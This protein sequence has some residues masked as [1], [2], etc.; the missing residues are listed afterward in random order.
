[1]NTTTLCPGSIVRFGAETEYRRSAVVLKDGCFLEV[2]W[3]GMKAGEKHFFANGDAWSFSFMGE[4]A[5]LADGI[6]KGAITVEAP[7]A[8]KENGGQ[9]MNEATAEVPKDIQRLHELHLMFGLRPT[10]MYKTSSYGKYINGRYTT[11]R[12][13][14]YLIRSNSEASAYVMDKYGALHHVGFT[15]YK[16]G[17]LAVGGYMTPEKNIHKTAQRFCDISE[18]FGDDSPIY[19][20]MKPY[21]GS[22]SPSYS[23]GSMYPI[24]LQGFPMSEKDKKFLYLPK[25][26]EVFHKILVG[27]L[28]EEEKEIVAKIRN[29]GYLLG[30]GDTFTLRK[31]YKKL[32]YENLPK[33]V[34]M[35]DFGWPCNHS[36]LTIL[37]EAAKKAGVEGF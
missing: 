5:T 11:F 1:M 14:N 30:C 24:P 15:P 20:V 18:D 31:Y 34:K 8:Q 26:S 25:T 17:L 19:I 36:A 2:K 3:P 12:E 23:L 32:W 28:S 9:T 29:T 35:V 7:K 27:R 16:G 4:G 21:Y 6:A 10:L 37:K 13:K 33:N 22:G